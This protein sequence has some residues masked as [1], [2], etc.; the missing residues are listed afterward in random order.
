MD[1]SVTHLRY[2]T[3]EHNGEVFL[4][5]SANQIPHDLRAN[6]DW[7]AQAKCEILHRPLRKWRNIARQDVMNASQLYH[8]KLNLPIPKC[9]NDVPLLATGHQPGFFHGGILAKYLLL[10]S[11]ARS[12][13]GAALNLVADS[14]LPRNTILRIPTV[15]NEGFIVQEIPFP[16]VEPSI[17]LEY[18]AVPNSSEFHNFLETLQNLEAAPPVDTSI[19][20]IVRA[21]EDIYPQVRTLT[22][23]FVLLNHRLAMNLNMRWFDVPVSQIA[24]SSAF[25]IFVADMILRAAEV[26][27]CYNTA[28]GR[29]RTIHKIRNTSQPLPELHGSQNPAEPQ[30]LPLWVFQPDQ[31]RQPLWIQADQNTVIL[32]AGRTAFAKFPLDK[33]TDPDSAVTLL[34]KALDHTGRHIRPRAL[35][36][37]AFARLFLA[38]YFVHGTGG[39][40]YDQVTN[41]FIRQL[42]PI[43]PP[44]FATATAT[45]LL[46]MAQAPD[47]S[48][49]MDHVRDMRTKWRDLHY[50][51]QRYIGEATD[52]LSA[53]ES[54]SLEKLLTER[55][56]AIH[57]S[58]QLRHDRADS[59]C[60][61]NIFDTIHRCNADILAITPARRDMLS[62]QL[63]QAE[64]QLQQAAI[65]HD[66]E[67]F[68]GLI[69]NEQ[70]KPLQRNSALP[71]S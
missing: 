15:H 43:E 24:Q 67:Y 39:A 37:T 56:N 31:T 21:M 5:P 52:R 41:E 1:S 38:D 46:P 45:A 70:L 14:D 57:I 13:D 22:D 49:A 12:T 51:P 55:A 7:F 3:P 53:S 6:L 64:S 48:E 54:E 34:Q 40:R 23:F 60:R 2:S 30:E 68:F 4:W 29:Y 71:F 9:P 58:E 50:N 19:Q 32:K 65:T 16:S 61:R 10:D 8:K 11:M 69:P 17:P 36:L 33:L 35:T 63:A 26:R 59:R 25:R 28:L 62:R 47:R 42:Y 18:Q 20:Y 27:C 66:R 44:S